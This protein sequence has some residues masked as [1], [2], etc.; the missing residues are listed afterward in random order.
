MAFMKIAVKDTIFYLSKKSSTDI[1]K[2]SKAEKVR[3]QPKNSTVNLASF[4]M[5]KVQEMKTKT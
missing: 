2:L 1:L 4:S 3:P 5:E